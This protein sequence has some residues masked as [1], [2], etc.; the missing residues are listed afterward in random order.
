M[1]VKLTAKCNMRCTYCNVEESN[2]AD[3]PAQQI[4]DLVD[5]LNRECQ[6]SRCSVLWHGGEPLVLGYDYFAKLF[7]SES[8]YPGRFKNTVSTNGLL[9]TDR[10]IELLAA[11]DVTIKTSLDSLTP[12]MDGPRG[13][14]C[15][16]VIQAL[17]RLKVANYSEV[18]VRMTISRI[19]QSLIRG[20]YDY[21]CN[22]YRYKWEFAPIIPGGLKKDA[23]LAI[24]PDQKIFTEAVIGIFHHW[25]DNY[26]FEI[27]VFTDVLRYFMGMIDPGPVT[28][29]RLNVGNDGSIYR[30]PLLI[31][32]H[33]YE[34][35]HYCDRAVIKEFRDTDCVWR[36]IPKQECAFCQFNRLCRLSR[37]AYVAVSLDGI[38]GAE[39]Y[40]CSLWKPIYEDILSTVGASLDDGGIVHTVKA[41]T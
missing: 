24:L 12:D 34:I 14:K 30:C 17:N 5:W 31:G 40:Y 22:N 4:D 35:G 11:H 13:R 16:Q 19:N 23:A 38:E 33:L 20:M 10:M 32:N 25:F 2:T 6:Q 39:D 21:M 29:P 8:R 28:Q 37:C 3:F 9:L 1:I 36:T 27:P 7:A 41:T 18:Y 15:E 26:P